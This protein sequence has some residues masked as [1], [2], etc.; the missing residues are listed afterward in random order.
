MPVWGYQFRVQA[1]EYYG[2]VPY[3]PEVYVRTRVLAL[4][5]Y[6]SRLQ[7]K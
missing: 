1:G 5:D 6:I 2:E 4:I 7:A 3:D